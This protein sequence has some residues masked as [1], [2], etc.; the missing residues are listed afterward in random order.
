MGLIGHMCH[1]V[2]QVRVEQIIYQEQTLHIAANT[3]KVHR[4][5]MFSMARVFYYGAPG[6]VISGPP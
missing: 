2:D 6:A 1:R 5:H 3:P 4:I